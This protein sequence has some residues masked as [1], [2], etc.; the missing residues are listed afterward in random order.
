MPRV[1]LS[2]WIV[3]APLLLCSLVAS[4]ETYSLSKNDVI[5][6]TF[7]HDYTSAK[8]RVGDTVT[9]TVE[10][11]PELPNGTQFL[12]HINQASSADAQNNGSLE[13]TFDAVKFPNGTE[14][15]V[16][17][18]P[19]PLDKKYTSKEKDGRYVGKATISKGSA[20]GAGALG[21]L[22]IGSLLHK[23]FEGTFLGTLIGI[24]VG[25]TNS[26]PQQAVLKQGQEAGAY[27]LQT[28]ALSDD[29]HQ[30]VIGA[31]QV[32]ISGDQPTVPA[33]S[34]DPNND[35]PMNPVDGTG[36]VQPSQLIVNGTQLSF[37][38]ENP[39][40]LIGDTVMVPLAESVKQLNLQETDGADYV[41]IDSGRHTLRLDKGTNTYRLDGKSG[42]LKATPT[43]KDGKVYVPID[44]F[45]MVTKGNS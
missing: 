2:K 35:A 30:A 3:L 29:P 11:N 7:D 32:P 18:V 36:T 23:P 8:A 16:S 12:G 25:E 42:T 28:V 37:S 1:G 19:I 13:I 6:V 15:P 45:I 5:P 41:Y 21:G 39:A 38:S 22:L 31:G 24:V 44:V 43:I 10:S 34:N 4:A 9:V 40:F 27:I 26:G 17:A 20:V 14:V 33:V